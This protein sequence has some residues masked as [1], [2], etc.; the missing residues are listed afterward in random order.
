M[1]LFTF[2]SA[3]NHCAKDPKTENRWMNRGRDAS[4]FLILAIVCQLIAG[5]RGELKSSWRL[6]ETN[7]KI[8]AAVPFGDK[9]AVLAVKPDGQ[10]RAYFFQTNATK[11]IRV[12]QYYSVKFPVFLEPPVLIPLSEGTT[13]QK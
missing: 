1:A 2:W 7:L 10:M 6:N 8:E 9:I 3:L 13:A 12:G 4:L 11:N 5:Q